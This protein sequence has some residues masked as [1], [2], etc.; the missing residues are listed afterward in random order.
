MPGIWLAA[1]VV[2]FSLLMCVIVTIY[3]RVGESVMPLFIFWMV[4]LLELELGFEDRLLVFRWELIVVLLLRICFFFV[5]GEIS[6]GLSHVKV[7][8]AMLGLSVQLQDA[9][10]IY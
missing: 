2:L 3:G 5:M 9:L 1:K 6:W 4:F 8:L 10:T 7:R